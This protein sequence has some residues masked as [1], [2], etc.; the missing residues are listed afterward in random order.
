MPDL[1][2]VRSIKAS[3]EEQLMTL[4]GVTG[5]SVGYKYVGGRRTQQV[6][7]RVYVTRKRDVPTSE[8]IPSSI[9]GVPTDVVE[10]KFVPLSTIRAAPVFLGVTDQNRYNPLR[11]GISIGPCR[12]AIAGTLGMIVIDEGT[13][14]PMILSNFHVLAFDNTFTIGD[15]IAQP[16]NGDGGMCPEDVVGVLKQAILNG[17]IDAAVA[18][19]TNRDHDCRIEGIGAVTGTT[20]ATLGMAVRKRGRTTGVTIGAVDS[21]D[22]TL[23]VPYTGV[24]DI[25]FTDQIEI[26]AGSPRVFVDSGFFLA[27]EWTT[28]PVTVSGQV[29]V[30]R[31]ATGPSPGI[32]VTGPTGSR[33]H[34]TV[35][36]NQSTY[37][38]FGNPPAVLIRE[39][40]TTAGPVTNRVTVVDFS[41][42]PP[43]ERLVLTGLASSHTVGPPV[44]QVTQGT[45]SAFMIYS[46]N[47]SEIQNLVICRSSDG[48]VLCPGPGTFTPTIDPRAEATPTSLIIHYSASAQP[49][50]CSILPDA[51]TEPF[52]LPGDS[53]SVVVDEHGSAIGLLFAASIEVTDDSGAVISP[54]GVFVNL[55]PI[56]HVLTA[57]GV[58]LCRSG[59]G[60]AGGG[61]GVAV[62]PRIYLGVKELAGDCLGRHPPLSLRADIFRSSSA[63]VLSLRSRLL[64]IYVNCR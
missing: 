3:A 26:A 37:M 56:E 61:G 41:T 24:G 36:T 14:E 21:I 33:F 53:G 2:A 46:S 55:N 44:V 42:N 11:G 31:K 8:R 30:E 58:R 63:S 4:P 15:N 51:S 10:R 57:L 54:A 45:G 47:G 62:P 35:S 6:S 5:V 25:T 49:R 50:E 52:A 28:D 27:T 9:E 7:I 39:T 43:S 23:V 20:E 34:Q 17:Q 19:I 59:G 12:E 13:D 60:G 29:T 38:V 22:A 32:T 48:K 40:T 16:A 1:E 18:T 64:Q